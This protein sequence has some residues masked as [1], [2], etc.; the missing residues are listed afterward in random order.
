[1]GASAKELTAALANLSLEARH[2][3]TTGIGRRFLA[4]SID[5]AERTL[6]QITGYEPYSRQQE[7]GQEVI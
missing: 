4:E 2:Y 7:N 3:L 6:E 5:R 1:M